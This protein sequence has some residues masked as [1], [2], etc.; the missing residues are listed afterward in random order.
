MEQ[1][2][3]EKFCSMKESYH[4]AGNILEVLTT[5]VEKI[6]SELKAIKVIL[7]ELKERFQKGWGVP[8]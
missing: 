8:K 5:S 7:S 3:A 6:E 4:F 1:G 2:L